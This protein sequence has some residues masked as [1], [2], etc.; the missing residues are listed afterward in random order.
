M[1]IITWKF[2]EKE[3]KFLVGITDETGNKRYSEFD[4]LSKIIDYIEPI[5]RKEFTRYFKVY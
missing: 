5:Q 2:S 1:Q 4:D 3:G